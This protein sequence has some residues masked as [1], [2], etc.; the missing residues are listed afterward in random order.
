M[1]LGQIYCVVLILALAF[2]LSNAWTWWDHEPGKKKFVRIVNQLDNGHVLNFRCQSKNDDLGVHSLAVNQQ[3]EFHFRINVWGTTL[4]FCHLW[5]LDRSVRFDAFKAD[6]EWF[7]ECD[8]D[9][10]IWNARESG[11]FLGEKGEY[12]WGKN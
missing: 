6:Q 1:K 12:V 10:C 5:Y 7:A 9:H 4:F 2:G 3:Y 11:I 8:G